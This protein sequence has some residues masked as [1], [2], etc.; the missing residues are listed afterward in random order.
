MGMVVGTVGRVLLEAIQNGVK[1]MSSMAMSPRIPSP[2]VAWIIT[3]KVK[4]K[5]KRKEK[6]EEKSLL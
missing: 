4:K 5:K 2:T 6:K 1:V 3:C